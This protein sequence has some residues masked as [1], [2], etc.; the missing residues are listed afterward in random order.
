MR[1]LTA[2]RVAVGDERGPDLKGSLQE[3]VLMALNRFAY[4]GHFCA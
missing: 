2:R 1:R 4:A 3:I